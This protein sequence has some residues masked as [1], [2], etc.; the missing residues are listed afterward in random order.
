[1]SKNIKVLGAV[2][3]V[4]IVGVSVFYNMPNNKQANKDESVKIGAVLPLTGFGAY[5]GEPVKKGM[6]MAVSELNKQG[7]NISLVIEDSKS[8]AT[9]A[10][11][12]ANKLISINGVDAI[13]SEFTGPSG[14][15]SPIAYNAKKLFYYDSF[16]AQFTKANPYAFKVYFSADQ[17]CKSFS[18]YAKQNGAKKI[19]YVGPNLSFTP[20]CVGVLESEFG[21]DNL[22]VETVSDSSAIDFR[23]QLLKVK[24]FGADFIVSISYE[25]NYIAILK[26]KNEL[27]IKAPLFCT[28]SEC[29]NEKVKSSVPSVA[30]ENTITFDFGVDNSFITLF[31]KQ[32]PGASNTDIKGAAF[33]YDGVNYIA[34]AITKCA[35]SDTQCAVD[36]ILKSDYESAIESNGFTS[37][38][39]LNT[40]TQYYR[41]E[42]GKDVPIKIQ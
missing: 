38:R 34:R 24:S 6:E 8:T 27:G 10:A 39:S 14:A 9:E 19:A 21:K 42:N 13:Y 22:I 2:A 28:K 25:G 29:Y 3:I 17:E 20:S 5:W 1:M 7:Y 26:Q 35:K 18:N 30:L 31:T 4:V 16:D 32:H 15:I 36:E 11:S 12:V 23:S 37:E 33:G 41:I 40:K